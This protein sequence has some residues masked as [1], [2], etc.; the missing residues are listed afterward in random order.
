MN[1]FQHAMQS[2]YL[3]KNIQIKTNGQYI[4]KILIKTYIR[5][6]DARIAVV[7]AN[8][9]WFYDNRILRLLTWGQK[10]AS[11]GPT[12]ILSFVCMSAPKMMPKLIPEIEE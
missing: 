1:A 3:S 7:Y 5:G 4:K 2:W 11:V 10:P 8:V 12:N 9:T 6:Q